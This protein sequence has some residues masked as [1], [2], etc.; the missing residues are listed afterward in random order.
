MKVYSAVYEPSVAG[1][2]ALV[3]G[4]ISGVRY[5][6]GSVVLRIQDLLDEVVG[7]STRWAAVGVVSA[8][9]CFYH[10]SSRK[11]RKRDSPRRWLTVTFSRCGNSTN[12]IPNRVRSAFCASSNTP[13]NGRDP[14]SPSTFVDTSARRIGCREYSL[15]SASRTSFLTITS[16]LFGVRVAGLAGS[17]SS[18]SSLEEG[19]PPAESADEGE[20]SV[21][22]RWRGVS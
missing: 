17:S 18:S 3:G 4:M 13:L 8:L 6:G 14:C 21:R 11:A 22:L 10:V 1:D 2:E 16:S 20:L 9:H 12:S 7:F 15:A 5:A 19:D